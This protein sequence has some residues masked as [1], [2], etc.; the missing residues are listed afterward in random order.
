MYEKNENVFRT[1]GK[2]SRKQASALVGD[3]QQPEC[4]IVYLSTCV[5]TLIIYTSGI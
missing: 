2:E 4:Y 1:F 3:D 5:I